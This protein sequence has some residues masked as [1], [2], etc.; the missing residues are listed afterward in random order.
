[1][2]VQVSAY[3]VDW[4]KLVEHWKRKKTVPAWFFRLIEDKER[5]VEEYCPDN[6][7]ESWRAAVEAWLF[8]ETAREEMSPIAREPFDKFFRAFLASDEKYKM[9][10]RELAPK[11]TQN[12][13]L[14]MTM[15]PATVKEYYTLGSSLPLEQLRPLFEEHAEVGDPANAHISDFDCFKRYIGQ[16]IRLLE[17]AS[18]KNK[19]IVVSAP[20]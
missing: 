15:S 7:I 11:R 17:E 12:G 20:V 9:R 1:M 4:D 10:A 2:G 16:W 19:G 13:M 6:W 8:Y 14:E 3:L 18:K 5:W